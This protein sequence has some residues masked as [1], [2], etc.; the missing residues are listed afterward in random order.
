MIKISFLHPEQELITRTQFN[1]IICVLFSRISVLLTLVIDFLPLQLKS[2][3]LF[4]DYCFVVLLATFCFQRTFSVLLLLYAVPPLGVLFLPT[5][6]LAVVPVV[7]GIQTYGFFFIPPNFLEKK[8]R[9]I[10]YSLL[11]SVLSLMAYKPLSSPHTTLFRFLHPPF[12]VAILVYSLQ[13]YHFF[14]TSQ[15]LTEFFL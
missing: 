11:I 12:A 1:F 10:F 14:L 3:S 6:I 4:L 5:H 2:G 7:K 8:T 13:I 15:Y 9:N